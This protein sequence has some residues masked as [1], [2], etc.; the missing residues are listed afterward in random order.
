LGLSPLNA[1]Y[2]F[3][4]LGLAFAFASVAAPHRVAVHGARLVTLGTSVAGTGLIVLIIVLQTSGNHTSALRLIGPMTL[5]GLGNGIA[6][7]VLTGV[8]LAGAR[9]VRAGAAAGVLT[10]S[11]QFAGAAGVAGIGTVFFTAMGSHDSVKAFADALTWVAA[12]DLGLVLIACL[13]SLALP[14]P[15]KPT[16]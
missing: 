8:V 10:T 7:P 3:T 4:P 13:T 5:I 16:N 14:R 9:A 11:Q 6:V 12:I 15:P 1:G 2:T